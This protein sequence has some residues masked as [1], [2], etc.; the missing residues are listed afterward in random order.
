MKKRCFPIFDSRLYD[1]KKSWIFTHS[2]DNQI[3]Q[4]FLQPT[5]PGRSL[6]TR[7]RVQSF[8]PLRQFDLL[9]SR[10]GEVLASPVQPSYWYATTFYFH[11]LIHI[12]S[13][14]PIRIVTISPRIP[15]LRLRICQLSGSG[16]GELSIQ[17]LAATSHFSLDRNLCRTLGYSPCLP[18]CMDV[19]CCANWRLLNGELETSIQLHRL[20]QTAFQLFHS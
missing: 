3:T 7:V 12:Q 18:V 11:L 14:V 19:L 4:E 13:T 15:S 10:V 2:T 1:T 9:L 17:S 5:F 16:E 6:M 8:H 20:T